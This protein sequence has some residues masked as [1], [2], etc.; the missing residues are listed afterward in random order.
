MRD[1]SP[2]VVFLTG[3]PGAGKTTVARALARSFSRGAHVEEDWVWWWLTMSGAAGHGDEDAFKR[4]RGQVFLRHVGSLVD[5]FA[6]EGFVPIVDGAIV[7]RSWLGDRLAQTQTRPALL[8][9]LAPSEE[10]SRSRD[11]NRSGVTFYEEYPDFSNSLAK[12]FDG[13]GL[14]VDSDGLSLERPL[15][16]SSATSRSPCSTR[17]DS[18]P[19]PFGDRPGCRPERRFRGSLSDVRVSR[20]SAS[21]HCG[22]RRPRSWQCAV[23]GATRTFLEC[24]MRS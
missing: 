6:A 2:G 21:E 18:P 19:G 22:R 15:R 24:A 7:R 1:D 14:W 20:N 3:L 8:V 13:M 5:N 12:E 11:A 17:G 10:T 16:S 9:V 4:E 23:Q